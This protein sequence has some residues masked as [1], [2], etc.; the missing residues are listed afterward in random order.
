M[1]RIPHIL[2][3]KA[4]IWG[5]SNMN[6]W[7]LPGWEER[8]IVSGLGFFTFSILGEF[9]LHDCISCIL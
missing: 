1:N 9:Q 3:G 8:E 7:A 4:K 5:L 6:F 2:Q